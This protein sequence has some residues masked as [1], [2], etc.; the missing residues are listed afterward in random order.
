MNDASPDPHAPCA[1]AVPA[2]AEAIAR[3]LADLGRTQRKL[4]LEIELGLVRA[5]DLQPP[6]Y[7]GPAGVGAL[8]ARLRT[9]GRWPTPV[10]EGDALVAL[11]GDG[12]TITLEPGGQVE[13]STPPAS[14][15]A[16]LDALVRDRLSVMARAAEAEGLILLGGSMVPAPAEAMSWMP[17][18]R[19]RVM[20]DYFTAL[21]PAGRLFHYMM[22]RTTSVQVTLDYRDGA[23]AAELVRLGFLAAPLATAVFANSPFD[24]DREADE[25]LLSTRAQAWLYTDPARCGELRRAAEPGATL[26]DYV[27]AAL[28]VPMMF[29]ERGG[30]YQ[31][32]RGA[33]FREVLAA[34]RWPDGEPLCPHDL[35]VHLSGLFPDVRLKAGLIELRSTDGQGPLESTAV[36][37]FWTGLLYDAEGRRALEELLGGLEA[38]AREAARLA[39]PREG[40]AT[41]W[42][43][44]T[45]LEVGR[46]ALAAAQAGIERRIAAG[47]EPASARDLLAPVA[48]RLAAGVTAAEEL[49]ARWRGEW[50]GDR[51][52]LIDAL[53]VPA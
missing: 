31:P 51:A 34:G 4:G 22:Q 43:E 5:S 39:V 47:E 36:A 7:E 12:E 25:P 2:T 44:R 19:Y 20:R 42:G 24:G 21:G 48:R 11:K 33:S 17:K 28:D 40:L 3:Y 53:R 16:E 32:M 50:A 23:D 35:E 37:A 52:R 26:L 15:L 49:R 10:H 38:E 41:R 8:L 13:L 6:R 1:T 29:R 14:S 30:A 27:E 9:A 46:E 45:L 18:A